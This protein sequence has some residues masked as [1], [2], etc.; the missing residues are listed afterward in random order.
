[1]DLFSDSSFLSLDLDKESNLIFES[2]DFDS[3]FNF[4]TTSSNLISKPE[5][6]HDSDK[7][8]KLTNGTVTF[9]N[10][11]PN[12]NL[13]KYEKKNLPSPTSSTESLE[14]TQDL[15][16]TIEK[17]EAAMLDKSL[18][19]NPKKMGFIPSSFWT[20]KDISFNEIV[21]DFFQRK[22]NSNC[23]FIHKLYNALKMVEYDQK[24]IPIVGI[25]WIDDSILRINRMVIAQLLR[26]KAIEGSLFHQQGNFPSHGFVELEPAD[27]RKIFPNFD[28]SIDRLLSHKDHIFVKGCTEEEVLKCKWKQ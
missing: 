28:F 12:L 10:S 24:F 21:S 4:S 7:N 18:I 11:Q 8:N 26:I 13:P 6:S 16:P 25:Q 15:T 1:M 19:I 17:F 22:N 3:H 23:R 5:Q 14:Q 2:F 27:V 20:D 9:Q